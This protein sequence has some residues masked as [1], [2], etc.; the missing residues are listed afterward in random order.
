MAQITGF[1]SVV[2]LRKGLIGVSWGRGC[3][4]R[5]LKILYE[6]RERL[7]DICLESGH[8]E[9]VLYTKYSR[10]MSRIPDRHLQWA[11]ILTNVN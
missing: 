4:G 1:D 8:L 2:V 10:Q 7:R 3:E 11:F 6:R 5:Y 9:D